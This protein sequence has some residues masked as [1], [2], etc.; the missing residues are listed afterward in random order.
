MAPDA[1]GYGKSPDPD[2][3]PDVGGYVDEVAIL[4]ERASERAAFV[5]GMS[6][7]G[8]IAMEFALKYPDRV[9]GLILGDTTRGA[10]QSAIQAKAML[11]RAAELEEVG[12]PEFAKRRASRLLPT[13]TDPQAVQEV[14]QAMAASI[15]LPGYGYA[16]RFMAQTDLTGRLHRITA[17]TLVIYGSEDIVTGKAESEAIA[18]AVPNST[19]VEIAGAGHLCNQEKPEQFNAHTRNFIRNLEQL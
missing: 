7:G 15:R 1:P 12:A 4:I 10:G 3:Y 9:R 16:A 8:V 13:T 2:A 5:L 14:A 18:A 17:P 6:W 19:L 11:A